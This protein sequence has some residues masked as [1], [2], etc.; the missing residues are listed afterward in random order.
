MRDRGR[1]L[2]P[3]IRVR[4]H[5]SDTVRARTQLDDGLERVAGTLCPDGA[6]VDAYR[7]RRICRSSGA[8]PGNPLLP[9]PHV[10]APLIKGDAAT[11]RGRT[12]GKRVGLVYAGSPYGP[13]GSE[14]AAGRC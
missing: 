11:G 5:R 1:L 9:A 14:E 10:A 7:H 2:F 4:Q 12:G 6:I 8:R 13:I 3:P